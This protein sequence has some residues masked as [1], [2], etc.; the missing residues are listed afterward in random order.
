MHSLFCKSSIFTF[1]LL[2]CSAVDAHKR[3]A[4]GALDIAE[5][6]TI[7]YNSPAALSLGQNR[8]IV[9]AEHNGKYY[10]G[11]QTETVLTLTQGSNVI[12]AP[13]HWVWT[14]EGYSG[15]YVA[16][17]VFQSAGQWHAKLSDRI[18]AASETLLSVSTNSVVPAVGQHAPQSNSKVLN[19]ATDFADLTTDD[20]PNPAFYKLTVRDAASSG[21]PS[22]IVFATPDLCRTAVCGPVLTQMKQ[23]AKQSAD[24]NFVHVE[25]YEPIKKT[26][27]KLVPVPAVVEWQLPSEPW[28]FVLDKDGRVFARYEGFITASEVESALQ[29]L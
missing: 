15:F 27:N 10:G 29:G 14:S 19:S 11:P 24:T 23:L 3:Q 1:C 7:V 17:V 18:G 8:L 12:S 4:P 28:I 16:N 21:K 2:L 6:S 25:I 9:R 13:T 26:N 22:V 20:N 5:T